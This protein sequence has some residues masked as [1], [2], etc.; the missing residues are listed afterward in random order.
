MRVL[1]LESVIPKNERDNWFELHQDDPLECFNKIHHEYLV[2]GKAYPYDQIHRL[3][4]YGMKASI[5][6]TSR[7]RID[8]S[9]DRKTL[10]LDGKPLKMT[11]WKRSGPFF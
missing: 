6:V 11:V 9:S 8:W 1:V 2:E 7:S 5:N 4:N 3:L 10:Y